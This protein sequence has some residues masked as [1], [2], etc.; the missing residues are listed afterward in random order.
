MTHI[1][2]TF[3]FKYGDLVI[4]KVECVQ[5]G[6]IFVA[7]QWIPLSH[8]TKTPR[9]PAS[10]WLLSSV[11]KAAICMHS[12]TNDSSIVSGFYWLQIRSAVAET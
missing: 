10:I 5:T 6:T 9:T 1:R 12:G 8:W 7:A 11:E 4:D 2:L 3:F